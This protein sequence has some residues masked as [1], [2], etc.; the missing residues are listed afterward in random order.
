MMDLPARIG[1]LNLVR[2]MGKSGIAENFE[3]QQIDKDPQRVFVRLIRPSAVSG[4]VRMNDVESR[5]GDLMGVKHPFLAPVVDLV[6]DGERL[7]MVEQWIEGIDLATV[8]RWCTEHRTR[9]PHNVFLHLSTQIC[10]GLE[11]LHGRPGKGTGQP[12]VLHMALSPGNLFVTPDG[13]VVLGGYGLT[14]APALPGGDAPGEGLRLQHLSPEQTHPEQK[15]IPASDIFSLASILYE[16]LI[17]QPLFGAENNLQT[18]HRLRRAEVTTQLLTVKETMPGLD[19]VLY[20]ALSLSPRHRYQRAFV[21]REDLRGLMAG[22]NFATI[23]NDTRAF[24]QPILS[25]HPMPAPTPVTSVEAA[26]D[27][28]AQA[29]GFDDNASTRI[30]PDPLSTAAYAA[31]AM[32]ERLSREADREAAPKEK[33]PQP[34]GA[35]PAE[36]KEPTPESTQAY[37]SQARREAGS[38]AQPKPAAAHPTIYPFDESEPTAGLPPFDS[39]SRTAREPTAPPAAGQPKPVEP[40]P[41]PE[42]QAPAPQAAAPQPVKP[43]APTASATS[44]PDPTTEH[45]PSPAPAAQQPGQPSVF[46][47]PV[48]P[49]AARK[50]P[51]GQPAA[52]APSK[53]LASKPAPAAA[54]QPAP[55]ARPQPA[56][57]ARPQP[58]PQSRS[59]PAPQARPQPAPQARP[60]PA[61]PPPDTPQDFEDDTGDWP[62]KRSSGATMAMMVFVGLLLIIA[63]SGGLY[64]AWMAY[65]RLN[66]DQPVATAELTAPPPQEAQEDGAALAELAPEEQ[67]EPEELAEEEPAEEEP[68]EEEPAAEPEKSATAR[69]QPAY[70]SASSTSR[71]SPSRSSYS[72]SSGSTRSSSSSRSSSS[73]SS[74]YG[75][76]SSSRS[77]PTRAQESDDAFVDLSIEEP[78]EEEEEN[79]HDLLDRYSSSAVIGSLTNSDIMVIEMVQPEDPAYTRSRMMLVMNAKAKGDTSALKRALDDLAREPENQYNPVVLSEYARYYVNKRD[80]QR[81]L[82]KAVLAERHWARLPSELVFVKK[83]EIYEVEASSYQGL[84][85]KSEDNLDLLE[86]AIRHWEKYRSH[87]E[88]KSR[89]DLSAQADKEIR[90]LEKIRDRLR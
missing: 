57:Q 38:P 22:Y 15:L 90:K 45:V 78:T 79:S 43:P 27:A 63:C 83:A 6:K 11:A 18:I 17:L 62:P 4:G 31:Q 44:T 77:K 16:L 34:A 36:P 12:N 25:Q 5:I 69:D 88:T 73:R 40:A 81:A 75:S 87:V 7:L 37:I 41:A 80:Y 52:S 8:I 84:F 2:R 64:A 10:N 13:R 71:S 21:L 56:P 54:P 14:R 85:Y 67:E 19:K 20:R 89:S 55:Q 66:Y 47:R 29:D 42:P 51:T 70:G 39:R 74:S 26:P 28:P 72:A 53:P 9:V 32:A 49:P 30:D 23:A 33:A 86:Q 24:L 48:P 59:Q 61:P 82:D 65:V 76:S 68:V 50:Q 35:T 1:S 46:T 58:A 3:A 60:Q